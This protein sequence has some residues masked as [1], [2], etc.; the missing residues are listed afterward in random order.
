MASF[1]GALGSAYAARAATRLGGRLDPHAARASQWRRN[2]ESFQPVFNLLGDN[3]VIPRGLPLGRLSF[4]LQSPRPKLETNRRG[5]SMAQQPVN[6]QQRRRQGQPA[7]G[8]L[9]EKVDVRF[10][11]SNFCRVIRVDG[12]VGGPTA[13]GNIHMAVYAER[14]DTPEA[15]EVN[16]NRESHTARERIVQRPLAYTREIEADLIFTMDIARALRDWLD[17]RL[18]LM[19]DETTHERFHSTST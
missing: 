1:N 3:I 10:V 12:A 17:Q 14:Q 18:K 7:P 2:G 13:Q 8:V 15:S 4:R 16:L 5:F 11:R 6:R 9:P 19:A